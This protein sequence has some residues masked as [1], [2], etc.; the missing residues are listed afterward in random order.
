MPLSPLL[1]FPPDFWREA[2]GSDVMDHVHFS[3]TVHLWGGQ[4]ISLHIVAVSLPSPS[5]NTPHPHWIDPHLFLILFCLVVVI[6]L[7]F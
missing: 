2:A 5:H 4:W 1:L 3:G 7:E 6:L